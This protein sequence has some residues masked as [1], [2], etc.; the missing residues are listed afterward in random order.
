M[1][2]IDTKPLIHC[3]PKIIKEEIVRFVRLFQK[4]PLCLHDSVRQV[5]IGNLFWIYYALQKYKP[6]IV[7][8]NNV[9]GDGLSW[10]VSEVCPSS[11]IISIFND[12]R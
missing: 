1:H 11:R 8:E 9:I 5:C 12:I 3:N 10:L 4:A 7:I 6:S 2:I